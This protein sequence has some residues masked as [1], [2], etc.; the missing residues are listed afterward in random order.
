MELNMNFIGIQVS[1]L[2]VITINRNNEGRLQRVFV[3]VLRLL[4]DLGQ[5]QQAR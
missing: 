3:T 2:A 5:V 4:R 1:L